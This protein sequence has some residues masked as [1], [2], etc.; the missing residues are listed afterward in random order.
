MKTSEQK[1]AANRAWSAANREKHREMSRRWARDNRERRRSV[2]FRRRF[3]ISLEERDALFAAQG[4]VCA[5]CGADN[6]RGKH[7]H[8]DHD[9]RSGVVRGVLC[10]PCNHAIGLASDNPETLEAMAGYLRR[11]T[12]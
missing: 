6:P 4:N 12:V 3:G 7:W 2:T 8:T 1:R 11:N 9:H 5:V 10:G